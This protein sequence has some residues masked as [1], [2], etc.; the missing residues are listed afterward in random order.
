V[1]Q[2]RLLPWV[3]WDTGEISV[4][5]LPQD[6]SARGRTYR[7]IATT[8]PF[9]DVTR[10]WWERFAG[11]KD[12]KSAAAIARVST[13]RR[14]DQYCGWENWAWALYKQ[15]HPLKAYKLLAPKLKKLELPGP[16]SGRAAYELACFCGA[17]G[18][19]KEGVR[20]LR[21]GCTLS[22]DKDDLRIQAL[23]EPDLREIWP[24]VAEL[25]MDAYSVFE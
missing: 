12:W 13:E 17:L 10:I 1:K 4:L 21:L 7:P 14:P 8:D 2:N 20:W 6:A 19:F 9:S 15:G 11:M 3:G 22:L 23:L 25:S 16:P 24:S 5:L 18:R